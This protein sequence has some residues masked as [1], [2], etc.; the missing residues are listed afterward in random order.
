MGNFSGEDLTPILISRLRSYAPALY[1]YCKMKVVDKAFEVDE[2]MQAASICLEESELEAL[3]KLSVDKGLEDKVYSLLHRL[4]TTARELSPF[5]VTVIEEWFK[6]DHAA[7]AG[8]SNWENLPD[9]EAVK[10][11]TQ[12]CGGGWHGLGWLGKGSWDVKLSELDN[13]GV[14]RACG[15]QL[16]TIDIDPIETDMFAKSLSKL[17]CQQE[18]KNNEFKRFQVSPLL[19]KHFCYF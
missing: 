12:G 16:V 1:T 19:H 6:S 7:N 13:G 9:L 2:H 18:A 8:K 5:T 17:A 11:A 14:C 3:L 15:E 10:A 4:R